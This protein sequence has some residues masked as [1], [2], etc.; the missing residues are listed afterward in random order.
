M[1][2]VVLDGF[3]TNPGDLSWEALEA[4]G[5]VTIYERTPHD[6]IIERA[7]DADIILTNKV[8]LS[9]EILQQLPQL[10]LVSVLATGYNII[11]IEAA[12][13]LGVVVCNVP[14]YSTM[15]VAQLVFSFILEHTHHVQ[16]HSELVRQGEWSNSQDFS[17]IRYPLSELQG[18]TIGII[19]F[20]QI[21]QQV[22]KIALAFGMR[23][24]VQTRTP[25][26]IAGLETVEFLSLHKLLS[27]SDYITLHCALT[28]DTQ[29]LINK[30][31]ISF[32]KSSAFIINTSRGGMI[33]EQDLADALNAE[34]IAGAGLDVLSVEPPATHNPLL[35]AKNTRITPHFGWATTEARQR[36][37][38]ITVEN[39]TAF[40]QGTPQNVVQP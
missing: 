4:C 12:K 39:I 21:G 15:A 18:K 5:Q 20:G 34:Q 9:R 31:S 35:K 38:E 14:G 36:L 3:T 37:L 2:I 6:L 13:E 25:K 10:K 24:V 7:Q 32:M 19:G 11:D 26:Q 27:Q 8:P 30:Q 33:I 16:Q 23:V 29:G 22:A 28:A 1:N 40:G 17:F